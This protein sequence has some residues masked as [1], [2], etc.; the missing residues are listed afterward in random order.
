MPLAGD[1]WIRL[2][3]QDAA[4]YNQLF[5]RFNANIDFARDKCIAK[6]APAQP[7]K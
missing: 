2:Q 3:T 7:N 1:D 5:P 6:P 4:A